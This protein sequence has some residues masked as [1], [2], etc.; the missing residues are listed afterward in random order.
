[1]DELGDLVGHS[2]K[3]SIPSEDL[4]VEGHLL[5]VDPDCL[6]MKVHNTTNAVLW[7]NLCENQE[8]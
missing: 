7:H 5:R 1:M 4:N 3:L 2:L 6:C 8:A